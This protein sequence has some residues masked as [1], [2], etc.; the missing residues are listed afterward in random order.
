MNYV[1]AKLD[2]HITWMY[3]VQTKNSPSHRVKM[4]IRL[5]WIT[6]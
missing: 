2:N 4:V 6:V 3:L 5:T 1:K